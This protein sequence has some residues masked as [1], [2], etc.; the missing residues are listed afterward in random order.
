[1]AEYKDYVYHLRAS[2]VGTVLCIV[3]GLVIAGV[4]WL[5]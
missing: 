2:L 1:M 5:L 4:V 3:A